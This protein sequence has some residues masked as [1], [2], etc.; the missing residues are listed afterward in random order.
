MRLYAWLGIVVVCLCPFTLSQNSDEYQPKG[1]VLN[2]F[3]GAWKLVSAE[4]KYPDGHTTPYPDVGPNGKGFLLYTPSG[5]M[6]AQLMKPDRPA[7]AKPVEPTPA[8]AAK[9]LEGFVSYCGRFEV[10]ESDHM[11]IH[12][13]ETA[14]SPNWVGTRQERPYHLANADRFFFRGEDKGENGQ[15]GVVWT[16]TWERVK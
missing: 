7:W 15:P 5:T 8:E 12:L 10:R 16:I 14:W 2:Y 3:L 4:Y 9:A 6:C 1:A 11:M 13:P